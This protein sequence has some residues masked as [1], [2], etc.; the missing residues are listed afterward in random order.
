MA[1]GGLGGGGDTR[2]YFVFFLSWL[3]ATRQV[4][5]RNTREVQPLALLL[6]PAYVLFYMAFLG[7]ATLLMFHERDRRGP[8]PPDVKCAD[9]T[10]DVRSRF[11]FLLDVHED[12]AGAVHF[13]VGSF[14]RAG[15]AV[16][17]SGALLALVWALAMRR[18]SPPKDVRSFRGQVFAFCAASLLVTGGALYLTR[19]IT[20]E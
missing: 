7:A 6:H 8:G 12:E 1:V 9:Y 4:V 15:L 20:S 14:V 19:T 17:A 2:L 18:V 10:E 13:H 16:A 5:T 11:G 3:L